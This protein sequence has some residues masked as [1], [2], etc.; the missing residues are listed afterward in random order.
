MDDMDMW[1]ELFEKSQRKTIVMN[2]AGEKI[3]L[4]SENY[5]GRPVLGKIVILPMS[6][7][8]EFHPSVAWA[9]ISIRDPKIMH[10]GCGEPQITEVNR[11][12]LLPLRFDDVEFEKSDRK[13]FTIEQAKEIWEFVDRLWDK[14]ELLM[15]H[16]HAGISRSAAVGKAVSE[17]YQKEFV[18]YF[19]QLYIPNRLVYAKMVNT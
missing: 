8:K 2:Q 9:G 10:P 7:T 13:V 4:D 14:V 3:M 16:C 12:D 18:P 17:K 5:C 6:A 19:D 1:D 11:L 15:I